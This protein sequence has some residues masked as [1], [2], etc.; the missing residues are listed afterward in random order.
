M[1]IEKG[2][3]EGSTSLPPPPLPPPYPGAKFL[4]TLNR[5]HQ[6]FVKLLHV[7]NL[8]DLSL[9]IEQDLSDKK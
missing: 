3:T 4:S 9:F 5:K 6:I 7:N 2:E 8:W 1:A